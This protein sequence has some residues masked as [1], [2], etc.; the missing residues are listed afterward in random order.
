MKYTK[1]DL[2]N[3]T[4]KEYVLLMAEEL[5]NN[6]FTDNGKS[7]EVSTDVNGNFV[8]DFFRAF[9]LSM[10]DKNAV[11]FLKEVGL[12]NNGRCPLTG[13]M[14][15]PSTKTSYVSEYNPTINY[16][17]NGMWLEYTKVK[18]NWGCF[19]AIPIIIIGIVVGIMNGFSTIA[20]VIM[21]LGVV[22]AI[23]SGMYGGANFGNNWNR[24]CLSNEIGINTVT[25]LNILK[26]EKDGKGYS[27]DVVQKY[28]ISSADIK[29]F[30]SWRN[31]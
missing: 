20:F 12:L 6:G 5:N 1:E 18:R 3:M 23:L 17:I 25:L 10:R 8:S 16:D 2:S 24:L 27:P 28:E 15:S 13:L 31:G 19:L 11:D 4:Y 21:G 7:Y 22:V 9:I 14:Y 26:I 30:L 29:A